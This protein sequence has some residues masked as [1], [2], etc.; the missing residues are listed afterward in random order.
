MAEK[1]TV[2]ISNGRKKFIKGYARQRNQSVSRL[3]DEF[4]ASL[5][6]E[7]LRTPTRKNKKTDKWLEET[8][9]IYNTG[10]KDILNEIFK[11]IKT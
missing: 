5:E 9:G 4:F 2:L 3:V 10:H 11:G 7:H 6:R 8:A 1:L